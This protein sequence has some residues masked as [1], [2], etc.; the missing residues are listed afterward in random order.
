MYVRPKCDFCKERYADIYK[1]V[2]DKKIYHCATCYLAKKD[3][4]NNRLRDQRFLGQK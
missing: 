3:E 1:K 4:P 2:N